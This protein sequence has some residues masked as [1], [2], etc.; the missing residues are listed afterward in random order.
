MSGE[1]LVS[2]VEERLSRSSRLERARLEAF[3]DKAVQRR[4]VLPL[5]GGLFMGATP[6]FGRYD[7]DYL[8]DVIAG[9][10]AGGLESDRRTLTRAVAAHLGYSQVTAAIRDRMDE[11]FDEGLRRGRLIVRADRLGVA[12]EDDPPVAGL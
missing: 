9:L 8:L 3:L 5:A 7:D 11:V 10:L 12:S 4:I 6:K 1:A 2:A